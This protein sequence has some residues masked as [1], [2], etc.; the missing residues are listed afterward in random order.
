MKCA[1]LMREALWGAV[2][3]IHSRIDFDYAA[4]AEDY[5]GRL[6]AALERVRL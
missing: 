5:F 2:S 6:S 3:E 1:S 4:Y